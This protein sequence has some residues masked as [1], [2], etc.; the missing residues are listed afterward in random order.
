MVPFVSLDG[1]SNIPFEAGFGSSKVP[2]T[3]L[4]GSNLYTRSGKCLLRVGQIFQGCYGF[5]LKFKG[6]VRGYWQGSFSK[7]SS[8]LGSNGEF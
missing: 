6:D 5:V 8:P 7:L 3:R 1:G 4:G 2:H